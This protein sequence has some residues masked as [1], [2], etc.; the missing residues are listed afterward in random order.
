MNNKTTNFLNR[1]SFLN[2]S[3]A[4][5]VATSVALAGCGKQK[6]TVIDEV[7]PSNGTISVLASYSSDNFNPLSTSSALAVGCN[8]HVIEGLYGMDYHDY[9]VH[10]ELADGDPIQL[11]ESTYEITLRKDAMFSDGNKVSTED[12]C[13]SFERALTNDLYASMLKPIDSI[14]PSDDRT[15]TVKTAYPF[16]LIRERL[17]ILRVV[18]SAMSDED[19][20]K[21]PTGSGPWKYEHINEHEVVCVPNNYYNGSFKALATELV[22]TIACDDAERVESALA[23]DAYIMENV[24]VDAL[25]DVKNAGMSVDT[26]DGVGMSFMLFNTKKAPFDNVV[27]RQACLYA[28]NMDRIVQNVMGGSVTA[29]T[30]F[31]PKKHPYYHEA[32]TIYSYDLQRAQQLLEENQIVPGEIRLSIVSATHMEDMAVFIAEDLQALGFTVNTDIA[33][34]SET[35]AALDADP[36]AFDIVVAPGDPSCFGNDPD[37]LMNWYY[38][39]NTWTITRTQWADS[40]ECLEL[41]GKMLQA[42]QTTGDEQQS[43]WN[44]C[45]DII[46]NNVPLYPLFHRQVSTAY[47]KDKVDNFSGIATTGVLT[48]GTSLV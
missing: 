47:F 5:A 24:P 30:S 14:K 36:N 34:S 15:L 31:L 22:W 44:D 39:Q 29:A 32:S 40:P 11:D 1:R 43:L 17:A 2:L 27:V 28:L 26:L 9:T 21:K 4:S 13:N 23:G 37:L 19:L 12:V 18:P 8:W 7:T 42:A 38:A 25:N 10:P 16:S 33:S 20:K 3:A 35:Y 48:L 45:Y 6:D 41:E 46:S